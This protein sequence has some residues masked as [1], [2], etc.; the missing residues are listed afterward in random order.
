MKLTVLGCWAPYPAP[1][2]ACSGYLLEIGE[3]RVLIDLGHGV[4]AKLQQVCDFR[5]LDAVFISHL[6]PDHC[7]DLSCLRHALLGAKR[8]GEEVSLPLYTPGE[9]DDRFQ[10]L[11]NFE[12]AF[13]LHIIGKSPSQLLDINGIK[14]ELFQTL[15]PIPT[16]GLA[17]ENDG[18]RFVYT[19]DAAWEDKLVEICCQA[20]ILLCETSLAESDAALA[21]KGH[22]TAGQAGALASDAGVGKLILTHFWPGYDIQQLK[23]EAAERFTGTIELAVEFGEYSQSSC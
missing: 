7:A 15:H 18:E 23:N 19:A 21:E 10:V 6:H 22:L 1:G 4:F 13:Q 11:V 20:D 9:P 5:Q 16:F 2:Q 3:K 12:D 8:L 14:A 17:V